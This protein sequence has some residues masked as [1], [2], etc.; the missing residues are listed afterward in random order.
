MALNIKINLEDCYDIETLANDLSLSR[1]NTVLKD[2]SLVSLGIQISNTVH[3]HLPDVHNLAFGP[4]VDN[5]KIDDK[6]KLQHSDH[7]KVFSTI[8][9]TALTFLTENKEKY[10]GIDG[11]NNARAYMYYR[12]IQNNFDYL[13]QFFNVYGVNY[14]VRV[15]RKLRDEDGGHPIDG[16]DLKAIPQKIEKNAVISADRLYN[17]FIFNVKEE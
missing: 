1:F 15:L 12:C 17:Y 16:H 9:F 11:S 2:G 5:N 13:S 4:L 6:I 10:L 3:P 7:S 14:Y 8:I